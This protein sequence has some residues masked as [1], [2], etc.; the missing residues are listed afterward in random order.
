MKKLENEKEG[1]KECSDQLQLF[2]NSNQ[3]VST[4]KRIHDSSFFQNVAPS[5]I[6]CP[7]ENITSTP[8]KQAGYNEQKAIIENKID[9]SRPDDC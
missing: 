3:E 9:L 6:F 4:N 8:K 5:K 1:P 7:N 2:G